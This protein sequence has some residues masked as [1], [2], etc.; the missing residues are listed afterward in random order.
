MKNYFKRS[1]R[2]EADRHISKVIF[3]L[4]VIYDPPSGGFLRCI[5]GDNYREK[6]KWLPDN[7]LPNPQD[8]V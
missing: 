1:A 7:H 6:Q 2:T 3:D 8:V 5:E 4:M